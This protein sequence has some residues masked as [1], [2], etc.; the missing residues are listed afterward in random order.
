ML[1][2][3]LL[4]A[5]L[6]AV[7]LVG[8]E[9]IHLGGLILPVPAGF[10]PFLPRP[11]EAGAR[12]EIPREGSLRFLDV[13]PARVEQE[14]ALEEAVTI[15]FEIQFLPAAMTLGQA[16][17]SYR[18]G[19]A[20]DTQALPELAEVAAGPFAGRLL[21]VRGM[22]EDRPSLTAIWILQETGTDVVIAIELGARGAEAI[23]RAPEVVA[24]MLLGSRR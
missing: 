5:V 9:Q 4:L 23:V 18:Q 14:P 15:A 19:L 20:E 12:L 22:D 3:L 21:S 2:R 6:I 13:D 1:R 16:A 8:A 17:D 7:P 10:H 24:A 11:L